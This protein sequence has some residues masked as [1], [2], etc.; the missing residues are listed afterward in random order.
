[1]ERA[2]NQTFIHN[3]TEKQFQALG[4]LYDNVTDF[5]LFGG[6]AGGGKSWVGCEWLLALCLN[7]PGIGAFIGRKVLK[8]LKRTTLRTF[9]KVAKYYGIKEGVY[10]IYH[11]QAATISFYNG[12]YIDLLELKLQPQ[13][14]DFEDLGSL[15]YTCGWIEE[16]GETAFGAFD[17]MK[18]RVGRLHNEKYKLKGKI[19]ITCNPKKNWMYTYIYK[20]YKL[21]TLPPNYQFLQSLIDDNPKNEPGYKQ[22]LEQ[23]KDPIKKQRLMFGNW[24]YDSDDDAMCNYDAL[25]DMFTNSFIPGGEKYITIDV[26]MQGSDVFRLGYWSGWRLEALYDMAKC[27]PDEAVEFI[28]TRAEY[29]RVERSHIVYDADGL[30]VY[31]T[32]YLKGAKPFHNGA[33]AMK[34]KGGHKGIKGSD[35][36]ENYQNLQVQCVY[37]LCD[38]IND[39]EI[40]IADATP[41]EQEM[42]IEEMEQ[43]KKRDQDS[44][45]TLKI[46][47]KVE[48]KANIGRS[49]D[50]RDLM[51]MRY[52]FELVATGSMT[53]TRF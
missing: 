34:P 33:R 27:K 4:I 16:G 8:N 31:L 9:K 48:I 32:G 6:G 26:A 28:K 15:E 50:F 52:Y 2:G 38:K 18:T 17:T 41:G 36:K 29:H 14:P 51:L 23:I 5:L 49:P 39:H 45:G 12:S 22:M 3:P 35:V 11:E 44:D 47:Q 1:M 37:G 19:L 7:F 24:E 43:C 46:M 21:G 25:N 42:I 10:F 40:Y 20:P 13:D 30:G 53:V